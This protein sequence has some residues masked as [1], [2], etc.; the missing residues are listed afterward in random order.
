MRRNL[1]FTGSPLGEWF[2]P[3]TLPKTADLMARVQAD[4][5]YYIWTQKYRFDRARPWELEPR[6]ERLE[7]PNFP[8]YPSAHSGNS[9]V[10]AFVF[11]ELMPEQRDVFHRGAAEL[12]FSRE[13]L[14]VHFPSDSAAGRSLA[15]QIVDRLRTVPR[16]REDLEAARAEIAAAR[17]TAAAATAG[18]AKNGDCF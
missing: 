18:A 13:I 5:S 3:E 11:E 1:F 2:G 14:G 7:T 9:W 12:A 16:F 17:K 10:A 15:R 4:A 6:L 8:A